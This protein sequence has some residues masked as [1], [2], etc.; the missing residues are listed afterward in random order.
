MIDINACLIVCKFGDF[1]NVSEILGT[2]CR[3]VTIKPNW[4]FR[5]KGYVI[6]MTGFLWQMF[7][8]T[9]YLVLPNHF[10]A[11]HLYWLSGTYTPLYS[12][13]YV[14]TIWYLHTLIHVQH[15]ICTAYLVFTHPYTAYHLYWLSGTNTPLYSYHL[16]WLSGTNTSL[17]SITSVLTIWF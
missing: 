4:F 15:K 12:I 2:S 10:T 14:L 17:Y 5:S 16:Y 8:C 13:P 11:Y 3:T 9:N 7:Y 6:S 1:W